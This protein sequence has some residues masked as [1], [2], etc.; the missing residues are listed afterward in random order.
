MRRIQA[1]LNWEE[2][3]P[4]LVET[5]FRDIMNKDIDVEVINANFSWGGKL[6]SDTKKTAQKTEESKESEKHQINTE[7]GIIDNFHP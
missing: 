3:N 4:Q 1:F 7:K 6:D 5:H 2:I